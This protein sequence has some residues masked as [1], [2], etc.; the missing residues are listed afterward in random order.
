MPKTSNRT[1]PESPKRKTCRTC[2][3]NLP[4]EDFGKDA[5]SADGL[6]SRCRQCTNKAKNAYYHQNRIKIGAQ[7]KERRLRE[8][9]WEEKYGG[10]QEEPD[11]G[12]LLEDSPFPDV[13]IEEPDDEQLGEELYVFGS[14]RDRP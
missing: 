8:A 3:Q 5:S 11:P 2:R 6:T 7:T 14:S 13:G 4:V 10:E 1:D 9:A 12:D